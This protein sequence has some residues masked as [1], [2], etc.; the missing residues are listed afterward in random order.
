MK[1]GETIKKLSDE[2]SSKYS[3]AHELYKLISKIDDFNRLVDWKFPEYK[4][5]EID[6]KIY[7]DKENI[8]NEIHA[9]ESEKTRLEDEVKN[10]LLKHK[11]DFIFNFGKTVY[12]GDGRGKRYDLTLR[13][14]TLVKNYPILEKKIVPML[15]SS[16]EISKALYNYALEKAKE[17]K[18]E[19]FQI[20]MDEDRKNW[21][22][23]HRVDC[24]WWLDDFNEAVDIKKFIPEIDE[25]IKAVTA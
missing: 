8:Y 14:T 6:E 10:E 1:Y 16:K 21:C 15:E 24:S 13:Y 9:L 18:L 22:N 11:R 25:I 12:Y 20:D 17:E 23:L 4:K 5:A 19:N 3:Q 2:I 7:S